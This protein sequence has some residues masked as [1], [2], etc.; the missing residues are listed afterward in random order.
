MDASAFENLDIACAQAGKEIAEKSPK[1][2]EKTLI[3]ALAVLEEQGIYALFLLL[4]ARSGKGKS[5]EC[6]IDSKISDLLKKT[7]KQSPLLSG[8]GDLYNNNNNLYNSLQRMSEDL[9]RLLLA[10][11]LIRQTLVYACYHA[12]MQQGDQ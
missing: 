3:D 10:R 6:E 2:L 11:D 12:R 1:G 9:D 7:P 5:A 8:G 4:E